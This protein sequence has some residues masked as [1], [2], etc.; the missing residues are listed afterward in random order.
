[1]AIRHH[2]HLA[3]ATRM[4]LGSLSV[5]LSIPLAALLA[6]ATT[7]AAT[8]P[9][10]V[11]VTLTPTSAFVVNAN[12]TVTHSTTGLTWKQCIEGMSGIG[13]ATG[14]QTRGRWYAALTAAKNSTFAG[15]SDWRLPSNQ[16]LQSL[17]DDT[18]YSPAI[19]DAVFPG[20]PNVPSWTNT[21]LAPLPSYAGH[22]DFTHG[23]TGNTGKTIDIVSRLVRG[24]QSFDGLSHPCDLD[25][26]GDTLLTADKDGVLLLRYMLG[27]RGAALIAGVPLGAARADALA[28][29]T[30]IGSSAQYDVFGQPSTPANAMQDGLV[31]LRLMQGVADSALLNGIA[32]PPGATF[33]TGLTVR[34]NVNTRCGSTY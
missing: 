22:V 26:S 2:L 25:V 15:F 33:T 8:C 10:N 28:V 4:F 17:I 3:T 11:G 29:E 32:L 1:M 24:G 21:T 6:S 19:N 12:G 20:T 30:F 16:E 23:E 5:F 14:T 34:G 18:C 7:Y 9:G 31:L 13:C 27:M